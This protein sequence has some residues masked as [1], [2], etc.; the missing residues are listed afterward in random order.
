LDRNPGERPKCGERRS[1]EASRVERLMEGG[2]KLTL[3]VGGCALEGV[4][5]GPAF[6]A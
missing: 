6:G 5:D 3:H 2:M 1:R 4:E